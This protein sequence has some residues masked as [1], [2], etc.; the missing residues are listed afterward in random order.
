M[1]T[2]EAVKNLSTGL[3]AALALMTAAGPLGIDMYLPGLPT[4][5]EDLNTTA[6]MTQFTITG[7]MV[8]MAVGNLLL[9]AISD[10]T[11]R[12]RPIVTASAVFFVASVLCA[13]APSIEFLIAARMLQG[14]A[15]GTAMV[16]ARAIIPDIAHGNEA[17]KAFSVMMAITGFAP[18]IAPV[19]GSLLLPTFG[20]RGVF[21]LLAIINLLQV[22]VGV[23]WIKE[24]LPVAN[25]SAGAV[26]NLFPRIWLCLKRPEFV[27]YMLASGMGFGALFSYISGSPLVLQSQL[28]VSPALYG[29]IFGSMALLLPVSNMLNIRAVNR[30][31]PHTLLRVAL[32]ADLLAG[33]ALLVLSRFHPPLVLVIPFLAVFSLMAGLIMP[34][35][36]ALGVETV[37]DIGSGAGN[38]AM[39][40]FQFIVAGTAAPL[41]ALGSN[42]LL[43]LGLCVVAWATAALLALRLLSAKSAR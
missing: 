39:G 25:R 8:G 26:R 38:G 21:W 31:S 24:T 22:L 2:N 33:A 35:A 16:V 12:K 29:V 18:A 37:R 27:G 32:A 36:T 7:F 40:F 23:L 10:S 43:T 41:V 13:I 3:L 34:N 30:F 1:T 19:V 14:L 4:L 5:A 20:W 15:G 28:G 42:H 17:A 9:G 11:G 6:A